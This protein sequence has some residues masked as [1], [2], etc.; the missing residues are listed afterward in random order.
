MVQGI[1]C[2]TPYPTSVPPQKSSG[3]A[4]DVSLLDPSQRWDFAAS[5]PVGTC[6]WPSPQRATSRL[7][8]GQAALMV[9]MVADQRQQIFTC[10]WM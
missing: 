8:Q 1:R 2:F 9:L 5:F 7:P 10:S 6:G 4:E 3:Q